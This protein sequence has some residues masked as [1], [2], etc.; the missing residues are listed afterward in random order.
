M[1]W[2]RFAI[3]SDYAQTHIVNGISPKKAEKRSEELLCNGMGEATSA[4]A[5]TPEVLQ[6]TPPSYVARN[7]AAQVEPENGLLFSLLQNLLSMFSRTNCF[8]NG[9]AW[10]VEKDV[11]LSV[12]FKSSSKQEA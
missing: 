5:T 7:A 1:S 6:A 12:V 4:S 11:V 2:L 10:D 8:G 3:H 9:T